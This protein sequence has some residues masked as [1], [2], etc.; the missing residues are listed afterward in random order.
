M[1]S[2]E[3]NPTKLPLKNSCFSKGGAGGVHRFRGRGCIWVGDVQFLHYI[4][5]NQQIE[6]KQLFQLQRPIQIRMPMQWSISCWMICAVQ[7][8]KVLSRV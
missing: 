8:V 5:K 4:V 7:P 1:A 3:R 2:R 6:Q